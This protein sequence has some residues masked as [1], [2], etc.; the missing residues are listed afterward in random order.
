MIKSILKSDNIKLI[1][2]RIKNGVT[3]STVSENCCQDSLKL[4]YKITQLFIY[5]TFRV[6]SVTVFFFVQC[7]L[8]FS[9]IVFRRLNNPFCLQNSA[10]LNDVFGNISDSL[11]MDPLL[12]YKFPM[13]KKNLTKT[14][15]TYIK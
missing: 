8:F 11:R 2:V 9:V 12:S 4:G 5:K 15:K 10:F 3:Y 7:L 6:F 1:D 13:A 14:I